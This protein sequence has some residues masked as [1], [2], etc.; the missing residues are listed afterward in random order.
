MTFFCPKRSEEKHPPTWNIIFAKRVHYYIAY[1]IGLDVHLLEIRISCCRA[2]HI[3]DTFINYFLL[4]LLNR[5]LQLLKFL[6][7]DKN[8]KAIPCYMYQIFVQWVI[9]HT[10]THTHTHTYIYIYIVWA[11]ARGSVVGWCTMLQAVRSRVRFTMRSLNVSIDPLIP[12]ALW[13]WGP[14]SL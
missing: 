3:R 6:V 1:V 14:L 4:H 10:H 7:W 9:V 2:N 11:G 13:P 12:V 5:G 8:Y